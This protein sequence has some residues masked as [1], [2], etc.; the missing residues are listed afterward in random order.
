MKNRI[1]TILII[2]VISLIAC[3][4][5][6]DPSLITSFTSEN[7][8]LKQKLSAMQTAKYQFLS[9]RE[10]KYSKM[11]AAI[12]IEKKAIYRK[13]TA[14]RSEINIIKG[15]I[16]KIVIE[17]E[18]NYNSLAK[19]IESNKVFIAA[20]PNS[21]Q[22]EEDVKSNWRQNIIVYNSIAEKNTDLQNELTDLLHQFDEVS[23]QVVKKYGKPILVKKRKKR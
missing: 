2:T 11:D 1:K 20:I 15:K 6:I 8:L 19:I 22:I 18:V 4:P 17:Y 14:L 9:E 3:E 16:D 23:K 10:N 21:E 13:D 5:I 12:R 7:N